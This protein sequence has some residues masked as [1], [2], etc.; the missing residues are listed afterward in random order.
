MAVHPPGAWHQR[1]GSPLRDR[2]QGQPESG[3]RPS[4]RTS[5]IC[6]LKQ[7]HP[8]WTVALPQLSPEEVLA[9]A[10]LVLCVLGENNAGTAVSP[11]SSPASALVWI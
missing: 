4:V 2:G 11:T 7:S 6:A 9:P 1:S 10:L 3:A 5:A 8:H